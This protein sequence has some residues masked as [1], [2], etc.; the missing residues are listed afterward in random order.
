M[1]SNLIVKWMKWLL[2]E[3]ITENK[4]IAARN[5]NQLYV[6]TVLLFLSNKTEWNEQCSFSLPSAF[7][8]EHYVV[9]VKLPARM[10]EALPLQIKE[11]QLLHVHPV[12]FNVGI[13]EQQTLAER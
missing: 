11:G 2:N 9:E 3:L 12:L 7:F 10:F 8:S 4:Q 6:P 13:N 5:L 1:P